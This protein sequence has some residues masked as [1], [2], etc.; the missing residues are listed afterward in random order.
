[1]D[2][3]TCSKRR[4]KSNRDLVIGPKVKSSADAAATAVAYD[5]LLELIVLLGMRVADHVDI[6]NAQVQEQVV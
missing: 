3:I 2:N 6:E 1:M 4:V 5:A